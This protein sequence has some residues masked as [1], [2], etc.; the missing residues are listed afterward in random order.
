MSACATSP[1]RSGRSGEARYA[2][3]FD[4]PIRLQHEIGH[5]TRHNLAAGV[6]LGKAARRPETG[7]EGREIAQRLCS[8]CHSLSL[9][10]AQGRTP[11]EW[12]AT[13]A[14]METNGMV[15]PADDVYAVIDYP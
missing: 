15:A 14:R 1:W 13:V 6:V 2:F 4:L 7:G 12:D 8:G 3:G 10:T 5:Q 9:V 11:E